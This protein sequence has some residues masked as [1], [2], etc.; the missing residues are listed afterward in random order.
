MQNSHLRVFKIETGY[1]TRKNLKDGTFYLLRI[2][3]HREKWVFSTRIEPDLNVDCRG[4]II[5]VT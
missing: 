2:G 4:D 3:F 1:S 5:N